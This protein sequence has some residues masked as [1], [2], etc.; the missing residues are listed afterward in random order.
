MNCLYETSILRTDSV[1]KQVESTTKK[2]DE[3]FES[4]ANKMAKQDEKCKSME[5]QGGSCSITTEWLSKD[6][7]PQET[8]NFDL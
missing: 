2:L 8:G 6:H 7:L 1:S 5:I 3:F 4:I